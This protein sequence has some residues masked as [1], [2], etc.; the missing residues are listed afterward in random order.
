MPPSN[1]RSRDESSDSEQRLTKGSKLGSAF[2]LPSHNVPTE[3][4]SPDAPERLLTAAV[5]V[6][7]A[8]RSARAQPAS[9]NRREREYLYR[10]KLAQ[11]NHNAKNFATAKLQNDNDIS[12]EGFYYDFAYKYLSEA[13][14]LKRLFNRSH[15]DVAVCG[16]GEMGQL[17]VGE[18]ILESRR[19]KVVAN[20]RNQNIHQIAAGGM[21]CV[22]LNEDGNVYTWGCS[23]EGSLGVL[24][25]AEDG[26][27]PNLVTGFYPS[28]YGPNGTAGLLD[29]FGNVLPFEQRPEANILQV[30]AGST[31]SLALSSTGDVYSFGSIRDNEGQNF[32]EQP[33]ED[34][35]RDQISPADMNKVA[36][37]EEQMKYLKVPRGK[38][39]HPVHLTG[40]TQKV[41]QLSAGEN[42]NAAILADNTTVVT[43]GID[44]QGEMARPVCKVTKK[45]DHALLLRE[46]LTPHPALWAGPPIQRTVLQVS[47]GGWH[48]LAVTR[49]NNH[50]LSVYSSGLNNHGQL[51]H[52]M[53]QGENGME[54][55][56]KSRDKLTKV[57]D[58]LFFVVVGMVRLL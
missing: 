27:L 2:S 9:Q 48:L 41:I 21:H 31:Q 40:F 10:D 13:E 36:N 12:N 58:V 38:N 23:D 51:G 20:L 35:T 57:R 22:A 30:A 8:N 37:G 52:G 42:A 1:K 56:I 49:E 34:D 46:H 5:S 7:T 39:N 44:L 19:F 54:E 25:P 45:T 18:S 14:K 24:D 6:A 50:G 17:G 33:P 11:L 16:S 55:D 53:C 15:G 4:T 32:R 43:W 26:F 47:C 29:S 28:Q 3:T